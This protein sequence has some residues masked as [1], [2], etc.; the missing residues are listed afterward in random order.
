MGTWTIRLIRV[1]VHILV[2]M[3]LLPTVT[4]ADQHGV[5]VVD[6]SV[7]AEQPDT[8]GIL[9][10]E[11]SNANPSPSDMVARMAY[12]SIVRRITTAEVLLPGAGM[13]HLGHRAR[14]L[15][16][17]ASLAA[18]WGAIYALTKNHTASFFTT[19]A[20]HIGQTAIV[21]NR[22][23][24]V[25]IEK[26]QEQKWVPTIG[27]LTSLGIPGGG[28]FYLGDWGDGLQAIATDAVLYE[29]LRRSESTASGI[30][31]FLAGVHVV[32]GLF[33]AQECR[34]RNDGGGTR[35]YRSPAST[36]MIDP[37]DRFGFTETSLQSAS[38]QVVSLGVSFSIE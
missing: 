23:R 32:E 38:E 10:H 24:K 30:F 12:R 37:I 15:I 1:A 25:A 8:T 28:Q 4:S 2:M 6:T 3:A 19:G 14:A 13:Y 21:W 11:Q 20:L 29:A 31:F 22:A 34:I 7:S 5:A 16:P 27:F 9:L 26:P 18:T 33:A 35:R 36:V 17:V